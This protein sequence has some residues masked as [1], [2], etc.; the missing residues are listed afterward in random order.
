MHKLVNKWMNEGESK[1]FY[2]NSPF[3]YLLLSSVSPSSPGRIVER[4]RAWCSSLG[5]PFFRFSP[6]LS[7]NVALDTKDTRAILQML[8]ETEA[9]L[10]NCRDRILRL[11][12]SLIL[13]SDPPP[14]SV[15][16]ATAIATTTIS[17]STQS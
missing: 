9:Y 14:A 8:W 11:V 6:L 1:V 10:C 16:T 15:K 12:D 2:L 17:P 5:V 7:E 13:A 3:T 4:S